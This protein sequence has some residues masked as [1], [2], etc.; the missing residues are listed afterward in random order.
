MSI[1]F[2]QARRDRR[3]NLPPLFELRL[4]FFY[5]YFLFFIFLFFLHQHNLLDVRRQAGG[6]RR[7][8]LRELLQLR[9]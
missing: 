5:F 4:Y 2:R 7:R 1:F 6:G 3:T 8:T 9:L